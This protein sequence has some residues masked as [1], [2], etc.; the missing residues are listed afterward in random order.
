MPKVDF[1]VHTNKSDGILS[2]KEV[3]DR[4]YKNEVEILAITDHDTINGL[5]EAIDEAKVKNIKLIP[6]IEFSCNYNNESIHLLGFFGD[7][8]YKSEDFIEILNNIQEKRLLRAKKMIEKLS[9]EFNININ[10]EDVLKHGKNI[11]ARPHIAKAIID[12]GY[13]YTHDYIFDNFIGK[14][15]PA[16]VPTNKITIEEGIE[17]LHK[18]N[19]LVF[20]A[21]P[22][23]IKN[24]PLEDFLKFNLDGIEAIYFLNSKE[25]EKYLL[26]FAKEHNLLVSAGSDCHGDF[27]NDK[28]HGDIGDMT[29]KDEYLSKLLEK[30]NTK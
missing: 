22:V 7:D 12:A 6:G 20:L 24:S 15:K 27:K 11:I 9:D 18:F 29:L 30:L 28:R 21:H 26:N 17:L 13:P 23:L 8:S 2:P 4:A 19:A 25:D 3:V 10:F 1:H 16:Y 5:S 14:D